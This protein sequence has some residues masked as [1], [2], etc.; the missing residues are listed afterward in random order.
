M[1]K[2]QI[3]KLLEKETRLRK[4]ELAK[5]MANRDEYEK[6]IIKEFT[7]IYPSANANYDSLLEGAKLIFSGISKARKIQLD[8]ELAEKLEKNKEKFKKLLPFRIGGQITVDQMRST[9]K[10]AVSIFTS[11]T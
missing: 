8:Q 5:N 2:E 10:P 4:E 6:S 1:F 9:I 11:M 7:L 3:I